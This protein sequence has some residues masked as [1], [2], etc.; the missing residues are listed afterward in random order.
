LRRY[1]RAK[2]LPENLLLLG[3]AVCAFNPVYGQGMT[4]AAL[5]AMALQKC[6]RE[7]NGSLTGLSRRFQK[8]LAKINKAPWLM[9]T[10]EDY[11]YRETIG[12]SPSLMTRFMHRYMD[13]VVQLATRSVAVRKVLLQ[14]FNMLVQPTALFKPRVLFRVLLH[15]L[16]PSRSKA[17]AT[18]QRQVVFKQSEA[19]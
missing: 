3:D 14:A 8:R 9:A 15:V 13:Q 5:G 6:L 1:E 4:T 12:G 17:E 16:K 10:G 7:R 19:S 2:A 11:R 18:K